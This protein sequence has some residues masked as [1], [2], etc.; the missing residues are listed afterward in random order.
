MLDGEGSACRLARRAQRRKLRTAAMTRQ[1]C[2]SMQPAGLLA[3]LP[4][5]RR[6]GSFAAAAESGVTPHAAWPGGRPRVRAS[7]SKLGVPNDEMQLTGGE[8]G[9]HGVTERASSRVAARS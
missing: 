7:S 4:L 2:E 6:S 3:S 5:G 1:S 9:A 8:G